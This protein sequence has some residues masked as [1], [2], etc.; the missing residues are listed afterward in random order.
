MF[1]RTDFIR[2]FQG[3]YFAFQVDF[4]F[5]FFLHQINSITM[6]SIAMNLNLNVRNDPGIFYA[7]FL[8]FFLISSHLEIHVKILSNKIKIK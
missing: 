2:S 1:H 5:F 6:A 4:F 3:I 7:K 8:Y